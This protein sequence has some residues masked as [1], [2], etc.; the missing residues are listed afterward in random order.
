SA[1]ELLPKAHVLD[2]D[3]A[4]WIIS[5]LLSD[6]KRAEQQH[7]VAD[8]G[9][10]FLSKDQLPP[11]PALDDFA[12]AVEGRG[13]RKA[14]QLNAGLGPACVFTPEEASA[15]SKQL[16]AVTEEMLRRHLDFEAMDR[17]HLPVDNWVEDGEELFEGYILPHFEN[18][19]RFYATAAEAGQYVVV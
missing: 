6:C 15:L 13:S 12:V 4:S 5:W 17:L 1:F 18:L 10:S 3:K 8:L 9:R 2:V 7:F 11:I 16:A 19:K 14:L